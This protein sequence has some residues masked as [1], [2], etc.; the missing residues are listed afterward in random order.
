MSRDAAGKRGAGS[1]L[2]HIVKRERDNPTFDVVT[3]DCGHFE[4]LPHWDRPSH[5][6]CR[7]CA[8]ARLRELARR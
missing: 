3:L 6:H 1:V 8:A 7:V 4:F 5:V 2:R